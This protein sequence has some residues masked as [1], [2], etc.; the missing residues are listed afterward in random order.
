ME[1]IEAKVHDRL[2]VSAL[3][4]TSSV[5]RQSLEHAFTRLSCQE[6]RGRELAESPESWIPHSLF[7]HG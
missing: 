7:I 4:A 3:D 5:G 2:G 6:A 1:I